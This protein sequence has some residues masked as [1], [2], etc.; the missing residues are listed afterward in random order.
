VKDTALRRDYERMQNRRY[1]KQSTQ[2]AAVVIGNINLRDVSFSTAVIQGRRRS[3]WSHPIDAPNSPMY[4]GES[5]RNVIQL[6]LKTGNG[7]GTNRTFQ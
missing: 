1:K 3:S 6:E 2:P 4:E 5:N 7:E